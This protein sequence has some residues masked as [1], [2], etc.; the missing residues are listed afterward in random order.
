MVDTGGVDPIQLLKRMIA[1]PS[2]NPGG[3]ELAI[4]EYCR[5]VLSDRGL[6]SE[7]VA[8]R[9]ER[10]NLIARIGDP[11]RGR[12]LIFQS[13]LDTKPPAQAGPH[14]EAGSADPFDPIEEDGIVYGLGA[15][16]TK[17]GAAAQL[18]ALLELA[19][20]PE[21][22]SGALVWQGVA[23]EEHGSRYG[24]EVLLARGLLNAD[25]AIVAEPTNA[26]PTLQQLGNCWIEITVTGLAAHGG[27]PWRGHDAI[28]AALAMVADM[29]AIIAQIPRSTEFPIHPIV[30]IGLIEG[31]GHAGTVASTCRVLT[32]IRVRPGQTREEF[33][34]LW[35][36]V[37]ARCAERC[38]VQVTLCEFA[39]GGCEP[40]AIAADQPFAVSMQRAWRRC[41]GTAM[42]RHSFCGGSDARYFARVGTPAIVL[43]PGDLQYAHAPGE[44]V[45]VRE[46]HDTKRLLIAL[47]EEFL[48][49]AKKEEPRWIPQPTSV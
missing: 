25:A 3:S 31:G 4:V 48:G 30:R 11:A 21:S 19:S 9:A 8:D 26:V 6:R 47:A 27:T 14:H 43:G 7:I 12:T 10:P 1:I 5:E 28:D 34:A 23:D 32:D 22:L 38:L 36:Q 37:A 2:H 29:R 49:S 41:V 45:P 15:C 46:V 39:G 24:A 16:D 20:R 17:G 33:I 13:H 18:A 35:Q 44:L 42:P 40:H